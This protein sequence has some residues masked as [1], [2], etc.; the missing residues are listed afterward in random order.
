M[1]RLAPSWRRRGRSH[2]CISLGF[3]CSRTHDPSG[4]RASSGDSDPMVTSSSSRARARGE[5]GAASGGTARDASARRPPRAKQR[6]LDPV[7]RR[8]VWRRNAVAT[9]PRLLGVRMPSA[10][11]SVRADPRQ[12]R[13]RPRDRMPGTRCQNSAWRCEASGKRPPLTA[14]RTAPPI[15]KRASVAGSDPVGHD[16]LGAGGAWLVR[17]SSRSRATTPGS[18]PVAARGV[19]L[20]YPVLDSMPG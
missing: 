18:A 6:R 20:P 16:Q 15:E 1:E 7:E 17:R 2:R 3:G 8:H 14:G 19:G 11:A 4:L 13:G 12:P 10:R 5:L 9:E